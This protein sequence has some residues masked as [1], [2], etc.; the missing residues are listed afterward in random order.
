MYAYHYQRPD[1]TLVFATTTPRISPTCLLF[2][3]TS[4]RAVNLM[5]LQRRRLTLRQSSLRFVAS[6]LRRRRSSKS[7]VK[8][9]LSRS[10][11]SMAHAHSYP[12][13]LADIKFCATRMH[14]IES[15]K[16]YC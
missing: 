13:S 6:C 15:R 10:V 12:F 8:G 14:K 5:L 7:V 4:T 2:L 1:G 9:R 16:G 11:N 3:I